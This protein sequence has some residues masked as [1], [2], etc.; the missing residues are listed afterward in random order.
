MAIVEHMSVAE[1]SKRLGI[2]PQTAYK[3]IAEKQIP[4]TRVGGRILLPR[5]RIERWVKARSFDPGN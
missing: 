2:A 4:F 5:E 3:W 1:F